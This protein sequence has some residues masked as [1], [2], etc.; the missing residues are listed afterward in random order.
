MSFAEKSVYLETE[1]DM[2]YGVYNIPIMVTDSGGNHG[3][4]DVRVL[5]CDCTT[6]SD[7]TG[8]VPPRAGDPDFGTYQSPN[9]TLGLW[10]ILAMILGSL[11]LLCKYI[12]ASLYEM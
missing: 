6:P 2:P 11:L 8:V 10:A 5:V 4:T 7:C 3:I 1:K 12:Y 9:V